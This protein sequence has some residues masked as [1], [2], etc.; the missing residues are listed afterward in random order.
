MSGNI[1][2]SIEN[3]QIGMTDIA[4]LARQTV[5]DMLILVFGD[6]HHFIISNRVNRH[7]ISASM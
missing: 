2:N 5:L 6:F 1:Q 7:L 4:A 3:L